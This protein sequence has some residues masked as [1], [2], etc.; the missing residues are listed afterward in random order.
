MAAA[1]WGQL[2]EG[3][4]DMEQ[5]QAT[6]YMLINGTYLRAIEFVASLSG[7]LVPDNGA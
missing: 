4:Y 6:A 3:G 2:L 1:F 5:I 7:G